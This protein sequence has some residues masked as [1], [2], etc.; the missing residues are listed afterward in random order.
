MTG[1]LTSNILGLRFTRKGFLTKCLKKK[2][3]FRDMTGT[4]TLSVK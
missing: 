2:Y 4:L 1:T 3:I